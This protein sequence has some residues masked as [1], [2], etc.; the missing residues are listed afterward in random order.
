M[1]KHIKTC[2]RTETRDIGQMLI[3][4]DSGSLS[5]GSNQFDSEKWRELITT[6]IILHD[7][8]FQ[9]VEYKG[10]RAMLQYLLPSVELVS[11]NIAKA[12]TLKLYK[13]EKVK[14]RN[15]LQTCPGRISLTS[16]LWT[17]LTTDGYLCLTAHYIDKNWK[18]HKKILNFCFMPPPHTGIALS[19]KIFSLLSDWG[20]EEKIFS[21][22]LDNA[23]SND[24]SVDALQVQLNLRGLLSYN[25]EFFHL[26]CCAHILNL[27]VQNGLKSI[28]KAVGKIRDSVK[29]V[30]GSQQRKQMF[31]ECVKLVSMGSTK[32][33]SQDVT[34]RW[35][36]TYLMLE[37][38]IFY[39]RAFQHLELSD[40]N[41]KHCL[42]TEEWERVHKIW[43]FLKGFY[44]ATVL[45]SG[46]KYPTANLYFPLIFDCYI[47]V[48]STM[49]SE[50]EYL[51]CMAL[52][53]WSKFQKYW[54]EFSPILGIA[55]VLDPW[56]KL[57]FVAFCY[58]KAYGKNSS[59]L[60]SLRSKL[61]ALFVEYKLKVVEG[62]NVTP[63]SS[64]KK[65]K[66]KA[67]Q[68][69]DVDES[70]LFKVIFHFLCLFIYFY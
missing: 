64:K 46:T 23:S 44:K 10:V 42:S 21:I 16:D 52:D 1:L 28:D 19:E 36:S 3:T 14:V 20:I 70:D 4:R 5:F 58:D 49:E 33:L 39:Q 54:S 27:I 66:G 43:K 8:P 38:A 2:P 69:M 50:D 56:Y 17:S 55:L 65:D 61:E 45:L 57:E 53:M 37:S 34:T 29:Y 22:T 6:C 30:K 67:I 48:K 51:K 31:L 25:G 26:R 9:F 32:G 59:E 41:Y 24:V 62:A 68:T 18:L 60:F 13:R 12:D 15:M 7:L 63:A 40:S 47:T 35:N 11:R